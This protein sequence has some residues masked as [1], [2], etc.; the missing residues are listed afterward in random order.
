[1]SQR[2]ITAACEALSL[3]EPPLYARVDLVTAADGS[4]LLI[5]LELAEPSLFLPHAD[6]A[7]DRLVDAIL[8]R[9]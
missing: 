4:P 5:E 3:D 9:A 1:M 8:A 2:A 6:G 7:A